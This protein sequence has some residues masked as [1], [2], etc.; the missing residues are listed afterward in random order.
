MLVREVAIHSM[1]YPHNAGQIMLRD[2]TSGLFSDSGSV[3]VPN[4]PAH[5]FSGPFSISLHVKLPALLA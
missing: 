5:S 2:A 4:T 1:M 3:Q